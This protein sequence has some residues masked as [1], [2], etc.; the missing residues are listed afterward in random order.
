MTSNYTSPWVRVAILLVS[1]VSIGF[2]ALLITGSVLPD[3]PEDALIFQN[4]LLLVVLGSAILEPYFTKPA[5]SMIN[6]LTG[7]ITLVGVYHV[8]PTYAWWGVF[9]YCVFVF[10]IAAL[11]VASSSSTRLAG[12]QRA[13]N[14]FT[15][16][17]SVFLGKSR[18]LYSILFLF[19][20]FSFYKIQSPQTVIMILFWG[21]F[22]VIWPLGVPELISSFKKRKDILQPVGQVA[23]TDWPNIVRVLLDPDIDWDKTSPK[24]FIQADNSCSVVLPLFKEI[25]PDG[26]VGTGLIVKS[27]SEQHNAALQAGYLYDGNTLEKPI[28]EQDISEALG[29]GATS[30]LIGFVVEGSNIGEIQFEIWDTHSCREGMLVW[31]NVGNNKVY[32]QVINGSTREEA[33]Q[34]NRRGFQIAS[35][36]QIGVLD[37]NSGFVKYPWLPAMN[38]PVFSEGDDFGAD[39]VITHESDFVYGTLPGSQIQIGGPFANTLDHHTAIL[40]VTG[41]GKTELAFDIIRYAIQHGTKVVCIDLT[42]Q[43][44]KR[45]ADLNPVN[46]SLSPEVASELS[47]KLFDVETGQYGAGNEKKA[48]KEFSERLRQDVANSVEAFLTSSDENHEVGLIT[49]EEISNTKATLYI[50]ELYLSSFLHF[51]KE[52]LDDTPRI[53]IVVE[54]AHTVMPEATTMGLGDYASRGIVGKISQ[55]ALQGRKYKVGLLVISQRTATVSKSILTQCNTVISFTCFDDTSLNFLRNVFGDTHVSLIPNLPYLNAVMFG[56]G[57]RSQRPIVVQI[58]FDEN[59]AKNSA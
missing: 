1:L 38:T 55:I 36:A 51:A 25:Q 8:A 4:A 41:S 42:R 49:L 9:L 3:R 56:K 39:I 58:P 14:R 35:A 28:T 34:A 22:V 5:D 45:L 23:R 27:C 54:E 59:K 43:Y 29:G 53:L 7:I 46:L 47:T 10:V 57:V 13:L 44:E 2:I 26:I 50:T 15:Y 33:F 37:E 52:H 18:L 31:C 12:W 24:I 17:P 19:G 21:L 30:K 11:C 48:L 6:A 20:L 32:Y 16:K 40:G